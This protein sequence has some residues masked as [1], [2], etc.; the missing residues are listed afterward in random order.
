ML[1]LDT[2]ILLFAIT[3]EL[4]AKERKLLSN[5]EWSIS[6]IVLWE[7]SKLAQLGR[8]SLDVDDP[9]LTRIFSSIHT[10]PITFD[11]CRSIHALDFHGDPADEIIAATSLVQR[12][13]LVTR[14]SKILR[15]K[16]IPFAKV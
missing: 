7:I 15:S 14:D 5:H 4:T 1:N 2:H 8:I 10:W 9:E 6:A 16:I 3:D 13:P 12:V 11:I